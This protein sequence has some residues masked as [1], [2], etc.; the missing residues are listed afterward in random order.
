[1]ITFSEGSV[2]KSATFVKLP[3]EQGI[4]FQGQDACVAS[5]GLRCGHIMD[6]SQLKATTIASTVSHFP[7]SGTTLEG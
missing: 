6:L 4:H 2:T 3:A 7:K 5:Q 1:M